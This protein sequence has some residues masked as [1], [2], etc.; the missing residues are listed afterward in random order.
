MT[1]FMVA[2]AI[3]VL[4]LATFSLAQT[5]KGT[6]AGTVTDDSGAVVQGATVSVTSKA[7]GETRTTT[8]GAVG[9]YR[10]EALNPGPYR[11]A[12]SAPHFANQVIEDVVV[13][14]SQITAQN[15]VLKVGGST[16]TLTV[17]ASA[18]TV[19]TETGDLTGTVPSVQIRDLPITSGNPY[20]LAITMPGVV[21]VNSTPGGGFTNGVGFAVDGLRPRGNNFL[22]DGFDNNDNGI[23]GQAL[24]P[25]NQ[26]AVQEVTVLRNSYS[27][28][29]GR[30]GS[31]VSNLSYKSGTNNFHGSVW[32]QY[33]GSALGA[34]DPTQAASG[35][36]KVPRFDQNIYG[37]RIGGPVIKNKLFL[38]GTSQ[39]FKQYGAQLGA[40]T[41]TLPTAAGFSSLQSLAGQPNINSADLNLLLDSL[42]TTRGVGNPNSINIGNQANCGSPCLIQIGTFTRTDASAQLAREWAV[43]ADYT[44]SDKDSFMVRYTDTFSSLSPDLFA[45]ST[46]LPSADTQQGGPARNVG[47]MWSHT[48]SA[49]VLNEIRFSA[50]TI[51]FSFSPLAATLANPI[52]FAPGVGPIPSLGDTVWGGFS[53]GTFPQ[54][55]GHKVFQLQDAVSVIA[56]R[57]SLKIGADLNHLEIKDQVP[58]N[59]DGLIV[60]S[61][62][63]SCA[64]APL[65][66][67]TDLENYLEGF[68]GP[69][70]RASKQFGS[71]LIA[72]PTTQQAYYI[73]DSWKMRPNLTLDLGLRYEYQP[74]DYSNV[75]PFPAVNETTVL[76]DNPLARI[77]AK[78]DR[79]NFGP[80]AGLA[81][82]PRFWKGLF[83]EN[84]TVL[85]MGYGI[86]YDSFF[87]NISNNTGGT[88]PNTTGGQIGP[89]VGLTGRGPADP[90]S[91][92]P[93]ITP[94]VNPTNLR[95]S[96]AST[97]QNPKTQQ[98]NVNIQREIPAHMVFEIAYVG[99]RGEH[100]YVN[101]QLNPTTDGIDRIN[102]DLGSV[103]VRD[104]SGD[105]I[106]HG[107][108]TQVTRTF[109]HLTLRGSYTYSKAIDNGSEVFATTGGASRWQNVFDPRSDRGISAFDRRHRAAIT[110]VY[111]LPS[112]HS[113]FL[114]AIFGGWTSAGQVSFQTGA[115]QTIFLGGFDQ[116]G[117]G[118][119]FNDRPNLSNPA[120]PLN[121]TVACFS[122]PTC[123]SGIGYVDQDGTLLDWNT[124]APGTP[125]QFRYIVTVNTTNPVFASGLNGNVGRN[126]IYNPGRQ[127]WNLSAIKRFNMP[128]KEGHQLEFRA[129][130]FNAFNHPNLG[131]G[132]LAPEVSGDI[133]SLQLP[134]S[135]SHKGRFAQRQPLVEVLVLAPL[136]SA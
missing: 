44:P 111:D 32:E 57:H 25:S 115:P 7:G 135:G 34:V 119:A 104:N 99:T 68:L 91:L 30:G 18:A 8:T 42:G 62:G 116:N 9:E 64:G 114:N 53:Q 118:E 65:G 56:G 60:P 72:V 108:Q 84:K 55:R 20:Q 74:N 97:L 39:W 11:V 58:F 5:T 40:D 80:R 117:D 90:L 54:G 61:K 51:D 110:W 29:F 10:V 3:A 132:S 87:T 128:W 63:G 28:E 4:L 105:S 38:F 31:S 13:N 23:G 75:L 89:A 122:D 50:Q 125:N 127:D 95:D 24:Q 136:L 67:C 12:I 103:I 101:R 121:Y 47:V 94:V 36:T 102:P 88:F 46:A 1:K 123:I 129:D 16:E 76:I 131:G 71:P 69:T 14:V 77:E 79:N 35:L 2:L 120:A 70:G 82:T 92:I 59:S 130:F 100:L 124:G 49:K 126:T 106:Y 45:N 133:D 33:T 86:F 96:V 66:Q 19:Q 112:W 52:A 15:V 37:F 134:E 78:P 48:F 109:G 81:Y 85:R 73:Q 22:L 83:G 43:R 17:E 6:I 113:G 26:E 107:L 98:W 41:L 93:S 27:A 21:S